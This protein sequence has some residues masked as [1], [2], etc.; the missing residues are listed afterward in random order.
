[1]SDSLPSQADVAVV[2]AGAAGLAAAIFVARRCP[3]RRVLA[4]DGA[5]SLGAKILVAG[6]GRCNVTN[7]RI[8]PTDFWG[9]STNV[10]RRVLLT[11]DQRRTRDFFEQLGVPLHEE[12]NGKLFPDANSGRAVLDALVNEARRAGVELLADCR[13]VALKRSCPDGTHDERAGEPAA[14]CEGFRVV[15]TRSECSARYVVL[16]AGGRAMP[17]SGSDGSGF[18]L[19]RSLGHHV[20]EP[21]PALSPLCLA[22]SFHT[23]L[24]GLAHATELTL[25]SARQKPYRVRGS[26]LWT[27]FGVSGPA[28]LNMSRHW[29][30]A[31]RAHP[32]AKLRANLLP[33]LDAAAAE[34][35]WI[36][37]AA[38]HPRASLSAAVG[39]LAQASA[40]RLGPQ[41][42]W[43]STPHRIADSSIG[44]S[45]PARLGDAVLAESGLERSVSA[46]QLRR[47][48]RRRLLLALLDRELPVR[49]SRGFEYAEATAGGVALSEVD[50]RTLASRRCPGLFLAGEVLDVDGR[51]GGFNFQW[52][53]SSAWVAA[54]G[55]GRLFESVRN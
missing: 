50:P 36:A 33:G 47:D 44:A 15:T 35:E 25:T 12:A 23:P 22:G 27:H 16:A 54:E 9:G 26:M 37:F 29:E 14:A 53:W 38:A 2:G 55:V 48:V 20:V 32:A 28:V 51:L 5:R 41:P 1:M 10:V 8:H 19:A 17:K 45:L 46:A 18:E 52:A 24:S 3:R 6:G 11:F 49:G 34:H 40:D 7:A 4:L 39:R 42:A 31:H 13:V 43:E 30:R 21:V